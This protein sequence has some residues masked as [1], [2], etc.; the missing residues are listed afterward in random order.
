MYTNDLKLQKGQA[1]NRLCVRAIKHNY[2]I[3]MSH[4]SMDNHSAIHGVIVQEDLS[5]NSIIKR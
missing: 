5:Y 3:G 4:I 2:C 1:S